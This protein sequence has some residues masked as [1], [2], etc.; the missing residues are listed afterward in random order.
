MRD[1]IYQP[2]CKVV[3]LNQNAFKESRFY[4]MN[5]KYK[6]PMYIFNIN[7]ANKN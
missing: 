4:K 3:Y 7:S 5:D 2:L 1:N 6:Q